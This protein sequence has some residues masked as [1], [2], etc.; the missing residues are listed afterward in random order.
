[1]SERYEQYRKCREQGMTYAEIGKMFGVSRQ[2]VQSLLTG[3]GNPTK[4]NAI[5]KVRYVGL[6]NWMRSEYVGISDLAEQCDITI[7]TMY[8]YIVYDGRMKKFAIDEIL[9]I[10]GMTYEE[11]FGEED[12]GLR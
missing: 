3:L 1:M 5:N 7:S 2:S 8:K 10:T 9:R 11:C 4:I 6:R 12:G